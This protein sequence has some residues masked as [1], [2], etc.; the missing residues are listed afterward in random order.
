MIRVV[1]ADGQAF[2]RVGLRAVLD[3]TDDIR[4]VAEVSD[5]AMALDAVER[6]H[7]DVLVLELRARG[8][9]AVD[10]ARIIQGTHLVVLTPN[11]Y[12][13]YLVA[14]LRAGASA[15]VARDAP[16]EDLVRALRVVTRGDG[17]FAPAIMRRLMARFVGAL[18]AW[19][20]AEPAWFRSL[21]E[22]D[23]DLVV[24]LAR[25]CTD[26]EIASERGTPEL[27]VASQ[28]NE[29][30]HRVGLRDRTQ[31]LVRV[32]ETGVLTPTGD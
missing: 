30:L 31:A 27:E 25:G 18:P 19:R 29:L 4:V 16:P 23:R 28:V 9:D 22:P 12:D 8:L 13:D 17:L 21:S 11:E 10:V 3:S 6:L 24:M 15:F 1:V 2:V 32:Y 7:P 20:P 26:H 5:G 14:A